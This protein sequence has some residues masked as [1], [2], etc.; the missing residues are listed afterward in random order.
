LT[1][2][3]KRESPSDYLQVIV[4]GRE[5]SYFEWL[6]AGYYAAERRS[7]AMHGRMFVID[8]LLF[9]FDD[10]HLYLRLDL[11]PETLAAFEEFE[12]RITLWDARETRLT[13]AVRDGKLGS[14][15]LEQGGMC[16]LNPAEFAKAAFGKTVEVSFEK[17]LFDIKGRRSL[18]LGVAIWDSGLPVDVLPAEGY[19]EIPLGD[20]AY[21]WPVE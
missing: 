7:S 5:S 9:G 16:F 18:L 14:V 6:G 2:V 13:L 4:D 19:L 11:I 15:R 10:E 20:V 12:V 21:A 17:K 8:D 1:T 3:V